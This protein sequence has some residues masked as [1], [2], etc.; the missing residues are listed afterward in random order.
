VAKAPQRN[1]FGTE[2]EPNKFAEF[3][4]FTKIRV[5]QQ[6]SVWTL[7]NPNSIREKLLPTDA[8][9]QAWVSFDII[10]ENAFLLRRT[11]SVSNRSDG[12]E[13]TARSMSS[14]ITACTAKQ[15]HHLRR[16]RS[17]SQR[18]N[19]KSQRVHGVV[20][21]GKHP[22]PNQKLKL[23]KMKSRRPKPR[24]NQK[25]MVWVE[26]SGSASASLWKSIKST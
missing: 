25:M 15:T 3:D 7:N 14:T 22:R 11:L 4:I 18:L 2:E 23:R 13:K 1:P 10:T 21:E 26:R 24:R 17:P 16:H 8:E 12:I 6:L 19:R 9:Q 20:S 5:L